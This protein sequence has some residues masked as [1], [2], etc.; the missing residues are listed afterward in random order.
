[1]TL[2]QRDISRLSFIVITDTHASAKRYWLQGNCHLRGI[3]FFGGHIEEGERAAETALREF[4]EEIGN[5]ELE[6]KWH[7]DTDTAPQ[8]ATSIDRLRNELIP[9]WPDRV[10]RFPFY[11]LRMGRERIAECYFFELCIE[12]FNDIIARLEWLAEHSLHCDKLDRS[13]PGAEPLTMEQL[14]QLRLTQPYNPFIRYFFKQQLIHTSSQQQWAELACAIECHLRNWFTV[15]EQA[16]TAE[17][18]LPEPGEVAQALRYNRTLMMNLNLYYG[19]SEPLCLTL[20]YPEAGLFMRESSAS[21]PDFYHWLPT[22]RLRPGI[23]ALQRW[24]GDGQTI[25]QRKIVISLPQ[26]TTVT[27]PWPLPKNAI[28]ATDLAEKKF[29]LPP[30]WDS[31]LNQNHINHFKQQQCWS[32]EQL[33]EYFN[34]F[35][36]KDSELKESE[37]VV[38]PALIS[39]HWHDEDDLAHQCI[40]HYPRY[41]LDQ[42]TDYLLQQ[43]DD[44]I[45]PI[46]VEQWQRLI[47]PKL[48]Y[49]LQS[50]LQFQ[51]LSQSEPR[52]ILPFDP[53]NGVDALSRL[54][55]LTRYPWPGH[56]LEQLPGQFRQNHPSFRN[57][58]CPFET[59]ESKRIGLNL[60]L[61]AGTSVDVEGRLTP[62]PDGHNAIGHAAQLV[63][64][65][66]HN[67]APR[68]MMGAKNMKQAVTLKQ[69]EPPL[70]TTGN[71]AEWI[72]RLKPLHRLGLID[73][74]HALADGRNLL[75]AYMPFDGWNFEDGMVANQSLRESGDFTWLSDRQTAGHYIQ[76]GW[77]PDL[78]PRKDFDNGLRQ[79]GSELYPEG[80]EG[81]IIG[82]FRHCSSGTTAPLRLALTHP[83]TLLKC[84]Y[85]P[86]RHTGCGGY[87]SWESE[88][89]LPLTIGDKLMARHGN[90]GVMTR[91]VPTEQMPRLPDDPKLP[92]S[93]RGRAVDLVLNPNGVISRMN[94]GQLIE[95]QLTL[96][97]ALGETPIVTEVGIQLTEMERQAM[98]QRFQQHPA[99]DEHGRIPLQLSDGTTTELGVVVGW[100][101]FMRLK[102][103]PLLKSHVRGQPKLNDSHYD[104]TTGQP[105]GGKRHGGGQRIGEMEIWALAAHQ[106]D[107][108]LQAILTDKSD[109][110]QQSWQA[111]CDHL[112]ALPNW[113]EPKTA[114]QRQ[115]LQ[116]SLIP[117]FL[118][119]LA[120]NTLHYRPKSAT[121]WQTTPKIINAAT[122]ELNKK[123][124]FSGSF[125]CS[126]S[127]CDYHLALTQG[128]SVT[129]RGKLQLTLEGWLQHHATHWHQLELHELDAC[130]NRV[131]DNPFAEQAVT[132]Y[133][134]D[135]A[136]TLE[137]TRKPGKSPN[138]FT[139]NGT[140]SYNDES[141]GLKLNWQRGQGKNSP[142]FSTTDIKRAEI[143]CPRR[144]HGSATPDIS[145]QTDHQTTLNPVSGGLYDPAIFGE[146][147]TQVGLIELTPKIVV[148]VLPPRYRMSSQQQRQ[149]QQKV[150]QLGYLPRPEGLDS[151]YLQLLKAKNDADKLI[152]SSLWDE[153]VTTALQ[154]LSDP[155]SATLLIAAA[156][157]HTLESGYIEK[158]VLSATL[159]ADLYWGL[160]T[161]RDGRKGSKPV[162]GLLERLKGKFGL[163]RRHGL[164]RRVDLS[165]RFVIV[166][167][168]T[169]AWDECGV[170]PNALAVLLGKQ[171]AQWFVLP[172]QPDL[173]DKVK[174]AQHWQK[175]G[176]RS[177]L[178]RD[179]HP[180]EITI[181]ASYL[182]A[183]P[184][185]HL[186]LNRAPSL[187]RYSMM[188]FR[189]KCLPIDDGAVLRIHPLVCSGFGADFDGDEMSLHLPLTEAEQ[190]Q[191]KHLLSPLAPHNLLSVA[192]GQPLAGFSQDFVLGFYLAG[193]KR[194]SRQA[195]KTLL[196][197]PCCQELLAATH[198]DKKV[199]AKLINH[200]CKT[201]QTEAGQVIPALMRN[202]MELATRYGVSFGYLELSQ[203]AQNLPPF[204]F[205]IDYLKWAQ[206]PE[207]EQEPKPI[208]SAEPNSALNRRVNDAVR[209]LAT[210]WQTDSALG[211]AL[212]A[213]S[214]ARGGAE[215]T[216]QVL[217]AR[218]E[219]D[220]GIIGF[221][222]HA[223]RFEH[224]STLVSGVDADEQFWGA[225]N[226]R[227][228]MID[229]KLGTPQAGYLTRQLVL[230]AWGWTVVDEDCGQVSERSLLTCQLHSQ[231]QRRAICRHCYGEPLNGSPPHY[232]YPAGLIAAQ[233]F[234]ERGTQLSMQ[235]FHTGKKAISL[236][237]VQQI[238]LRARQG[239]L[240][241]DDFVT[242]LSDISAYQKLDR[243]HLQL[244]ALALGWQSQYLRLDQLLVGYPQQFANVE[245][246]LSQPLAES[247]LLQ[248]LTAHWERDRG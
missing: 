78:T 224:A 145:A 236:A 48:L 118:L 103:S 10:H 157:P 17:F 171:I 219:L 115:A 204:D 246:D 79:V 247:P 207:P 179:I 94:L 9:L 43:S 237:G 136:F 163:L 81:A 194:S 156:Q 201:H 223:A 238:I 185:L 27:L 169:M 159:T 28:T 210:Q 76:P 32:R 61:S 33:I 130:L 40:N 4:M 198:W 161:L 239:E 88:R 120:H 34:R 37:A 165:G 143:R 200:L 133:A 73:S 121:D 124:S 6:S 215:Q 150:E 12:S 105:Y 68:V 234:G 50:R 148:P 77:E 176:A 26:G 119:E 225:F 44:Q 25:A 65:S 49:S 54:N 243:R 208:E 186:L 62:A 57:L 137:L 138:Q 213:H 29:T 178:P 23:W 122:L 91:F 151:A 117:G 132:L 51:R 126:R 107:H 235:S 69:P 240:K 135:K 197:E 7:L 106:A 231:Q 205:S 109:P 31:N 85:T 154:G 155:T 116:P 92:P 227:S 13:L 190:Q 209:Q 134:E 168:P 175:M 11:S 180:D 164:G 139:L 217:I 58:I 216:R 202:C 71:E 140:V 125:R 2:N 153:C 220:G 53:L 47:A 191:A 52:F 67:D 74:E 30:Q 108:L 152:P 86:P 172:L 83:V 211:F 193:E 8:L 229:K 228:S 112:A 96:A 203:L 5:R 149:L 56:V 3:N 84:H 59:P 111:I 95:T 101:F 97:N 189:P 181:I 230:A 183:H 89:R 199:G 144:L 147:G 218:G 141:V 90:K 82:W 233:S 187:H 170:S 70:L 214:G 177:H 87:L 173:P 18:L 182:E 99:F 104:T 35:L 46:D 93:L 102:Q 80:K 39:D 167:D 1:M 72:T 114:K 98:Q 129:E 110:T 60:Y 100:Q 195:I 55:Q 19:E 36:P 22:L 24:Q 162:K 123:G 131:G 160:K 66:A 20:P 113:P 15:S 242:E 64:F 41:I 146:S 245:T 196:P 38:D 158:P 222:R 244:I 192:D 127:G 21:S 226:G 166:P 174:S 16:L 188:A 142:T 184:D 63:P 241:P 206:P 248:L 128:I 75:V 232:P 221:D 42:L 45:T 212:L 14:N